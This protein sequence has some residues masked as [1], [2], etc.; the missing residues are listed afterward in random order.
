MTDIKAAQAKLDAAVEE[1]IRDSREADAPM[2]NSSAVL[3]SYILT[4][5]GQHWDDDGHSRTSCGTAYY[6][7]DMPLAR[8]IGLALMTLDNLRGIGSFDD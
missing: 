5:E 4:V 6:G 2:I 8:A 7:G 3:S 1:F